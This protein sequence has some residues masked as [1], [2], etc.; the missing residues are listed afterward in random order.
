MKEDTKAARRI[1]IEAAA[2]RL[3]EEK[4]FA[5]TSM[6]AIAKAASASNET[7]YK[8]YGDKPGLFRAMIESNA[9]EIKTT[10]EHAIEH[11]SAPLEGLAEIAPV[12]LRLLTG[13]RSI[14]L[15]R[16]AAAD[17]TGIL[18]QEISKGGR[19]TIAPLISQ[20][21]QQG[22]D[23]GSLRSTD[24]REAANLFISLL[25]GDLQIRRM[26]GALPPLTDKDVGDRVS[27]AMTSFKTLCGAD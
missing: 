4:G 23:G 5:K 13:P 17:G 22:I 11:R 2:Y 14:A 1:K 18:G 27:Q 8:W 26:I 6:L 12:L 19:E 3:L 25:I 9:A 24:A 15:N 21:I 10:L 7:L 16:A 20:L